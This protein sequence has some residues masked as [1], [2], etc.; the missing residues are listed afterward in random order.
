MDPCRLIYP[1][2]ARIAKN[3]SL[4]KSIY[5]LS[6]DKPP[7]ASTLDPW[8]SRSRRKFGALGNGIMRG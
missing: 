7:A 8:Y 5:A 1:N 2:P 4:R 6:Y 3:G